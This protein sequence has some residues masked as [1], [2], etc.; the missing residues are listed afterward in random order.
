MKS[1]TIVAAVLACALTV[2]TAQAQT[3]PIMKMTTEIP[4]EI[5][6]PDKVE[7]RLGTLKLFDGFPDDA[8]TQK[9]YD[10]LDFQR[11]VQVFLNAM[12]GASLAGMR[13]GFRKMGALNSSILLFENLLD[14]KALFLTGNTDSIY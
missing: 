1:R 3:P 14:S 13:T 10:N 7:T 11:G 2:T 6:T 9:V 8:T 12:P 4:P 5:T